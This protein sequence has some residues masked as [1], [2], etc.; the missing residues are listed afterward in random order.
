MEILRLMKRC[1]IRRRAKA[2]SSLEILPNEILQRINTF[3]PLPAAAAFAL[4][5]HQL[6]FV[7]GIGSWEKLIRTQE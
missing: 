4:S 5:S 3:L 6:Y 1:R 2:I 7:L